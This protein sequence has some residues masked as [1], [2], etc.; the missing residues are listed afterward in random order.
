MVHLLLHSVTREWWEART[1]THKH[2]RAENRNMSPASRKYFSY[3]TF[4]ITYINIFRV[5]NNKSK[6]KL[7][8]SVRASQ[9]VVPLVRS[10]I[11]GINASDFFY[12][13]FRSPTH[14]NTLALR[15]DSMKKRRNNVRLSH[16]YYRWIQLFHFPLR[17]G[18]GDDVCKTK[19]ICTYKQRFLLC[20]RERPCT[21]TPDKSPSQR[22]HFQQLPTIC[23]RRFHFHVGKACVANAVS[24]LNQQWEWKSLHM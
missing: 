1:Y 7:F 24:Y 20:V 16:L 15:I 9:R 8:V 10:F 5:E 3:F 4:K 11:R 19:C 12:L 23:S 13:F 17:F 18:S 21:F 22:H 2:T 14:A 6:I